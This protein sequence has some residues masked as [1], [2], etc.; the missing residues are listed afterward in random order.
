MVRFGADSLAF[1][2][3]KDLIKLCNRY[4][5]LGIATQQPGKTPQEKQASRL[6]RQA[7]SRQMKVQQKAN[8]TRDL[9]RNVTY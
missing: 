7:D 1:D 5:A 6:H 8:V 4:R 9:P 2:V 3:N